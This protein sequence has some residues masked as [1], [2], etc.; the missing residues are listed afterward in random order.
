MKSLALMSHAS[1]F[2]AFSLLALPSGTFLLL[3][4]LGALN[5]GLR[6]TFLTPIGERLMF[7]TVCETEPVVNF[8]PKQLHV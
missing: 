8:D 2:T 6:S 3:A 7:T 4:G 5:G 1:H